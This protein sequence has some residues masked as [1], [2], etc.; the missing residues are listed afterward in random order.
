MAFVPF[1][2]GVVGIQ[3]IGDL[4]GIPV[5]ITM[6]AKFN[7]G[8]ATAS[9]GLALAAALQTWLTDDIVSNQILPMVWTEID[10]TDLT[11]SAGWLAPLTFTLPGT[12]NVGEP[13]NATAMSVTAQTAQRGRSQRGRT[14]L[15][16]L[17]AG[18][19][20]N[21]TA[22]SADLVTAIG[23][24]YNNLGTDMGAV[25]FSPVVLSRVHDGVERTLGQ[26]TIIT[27]Y[28]ANARLANVRGRIK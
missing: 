2:V 18:G 5:E 10:V 7:A 26:A 28:R 24:A 20:I 13:S 14:F 9:D 8:A 19:I 11:S 27:N 16:G 22:W 23:A 1:G 4:N 21:G 15:P 6:G 3:M 25:G 12:Q 17:P